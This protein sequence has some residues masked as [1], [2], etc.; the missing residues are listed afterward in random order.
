MFLVVVLL[1]LMS[2]YVVQNEKLKDSTK[3]GW[4]IFLVIF[5]I[6]MLLFEVL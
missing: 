2:V 4:F 6:L 1:I 3:T 5:C